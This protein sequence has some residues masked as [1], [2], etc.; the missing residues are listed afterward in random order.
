MDHADVN[1]NKS[2]VIEL[3]TTFDEYGRILNQN[4]DEARYLISLA[5]WSV[6]ENKGEIIGEIYDG[7]TIERAYELQ[8]KLLTNQM[9][10]NREFIP[11]KQWEIQWAID[12][13]ISLDNW[14]EE[15]KEV[16]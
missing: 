14:R 8:I 1:K 4:S 6:L 5:R 7:V 16:F 12:L 11:E 2:L 15:E 13:S 10:P 3:P 9:Q